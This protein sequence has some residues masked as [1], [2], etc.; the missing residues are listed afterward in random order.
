VPIAAAIGTASYTAAAEHIRT[1]NA[2]KVPV[3]ATLVADPAKSITVGDDAGTKAQALVRW[4]RQGHIGQA[5]V[6]VPDSAARGATIGIWLGPDGR[7]EAAPTPTSTAGFTGFAAGFILLGAAWA[8]IA[9]IFGAIR[10][11]LNQRRSAAWAKE[12]LLVAHPLGRDHR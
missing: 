3:Q 6:D 2:T 1:D 11:A 12:W 4:E 10:W 9:V 7:P 5:T 8:A